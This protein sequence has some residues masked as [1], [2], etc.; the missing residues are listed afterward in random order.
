MLDREDFFVHDGDHAEEMETSLLL[1]LQPEL[2]LDRAHW[3]DGR[4]KRW[5]IDALNEPW[6]WAER[7]WSQVSAD[8][9]IGDPSEASAEKGARFFRA[10]TERM[11]T[12]MYELA[13]A[14]LQDLYE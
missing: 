6:A 11:G 13:V 2:V 1:H 14:D 12:L 5:R 7:Q 3:G 9:G 10:V 8:T 4:A